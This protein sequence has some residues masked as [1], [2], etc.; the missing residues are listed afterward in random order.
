MTP[1]LVGGLVKLFLTSLG[2]FLLLFGALHIRFCPCHC[3][4]GFGLSS[5][6]FSLVPVL[7][8]PRY[9]LKTIFR[10]S[11]RQKQQ[12]L[13]LKS[14]A[15][16]VFAYNKRLPSSW[17]FHSVGRSMD[18]LGNFGHVSVPIMEGPGHCLRLKNGVFFSI[19]I[20]L[21]D[22]LYDELFYKFFFFR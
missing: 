13:R 1:I 3:S 7:C 18:E 2:G 22:P 19:T 8:T 20:G 5:A 9:T 16:M 10:V 4:F 21:A 12:N 6:W 14:F 15:P 11:L 17:N